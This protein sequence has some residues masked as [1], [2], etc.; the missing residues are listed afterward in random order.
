VYSSSATCT[1][2][3]VGDP[4]N[5]I[6]EFNWPEV[7]WS[8]TEVATVIYEVNT[9]LNVTVTTTEYAELTGVGTGGTLSLASNDA[10]FWDS[11]LS[12]TGVV[13]VDGTPTLTLKPTIY[14]NPG[15]F[16]TVTAVL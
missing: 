16:I 3:E 13:V 12:T 4:Q 2:C 15:A 11:L 7:S 8:S 5:N 10:S 9:I 6:V 14:T 1:D